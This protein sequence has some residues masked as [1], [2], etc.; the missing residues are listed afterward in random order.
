MSIDKLQ[1]KIRKL[2]NPSMVEF[3][4]NLDRIPPHLLLQE[5]SEIMA[6][7]RFCRELL[8]GLKGIV[9]AVRFSMGKFS[10]LGPDG[11]FL[12]SRMVNYAKAQEYYVLLDAHK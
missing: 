12:L 6:Y 7:D 5:Q 10:L 8:D 1:E 4:L 3:S 11:M 9:P 2:K